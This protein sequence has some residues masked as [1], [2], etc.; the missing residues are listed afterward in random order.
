MKIFVAFTETD[1]EL[2]NSIVTSDDIVVG[3]SDIYAD[4]MYDVGTIKIRLDEHMEFIRELVKKV[5]LSSDIDLKG[6]ANNFF[7]CTIRP[8]LRYIEAIRNLL[9]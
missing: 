9:Y 8:S 6:F 5:S 7:E 2:F 4:N 1:V 3:Y